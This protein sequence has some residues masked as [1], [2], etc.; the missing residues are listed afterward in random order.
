MKTPG[1][2]ASNHPI[3]IVLLPLSGIWALA[4]YLRSFRK[5]KKVGAYVICVGNVVAGG[6][7]K[8]PVALALGSYLQQQHVPAYFITRGY[9]ASIQNP[10]LVDVKQHT[11]SDVGDEALL[12][13]K[14]LPTIACPDRVRAAEYAV[15]LG[16]KI[17]IMDDGMQNPT[18]HKDYTILVLK[19]NQP[20]GNGRLMPAGPLREPYANALARAQAIVTI[21][22]DASVNPGT[23][24]AYA[25]KTKLTS[26]G[27]RF[28]KYIAFAGIA[29]PSAFKQSLECAGYQLA[30]FHAFADHHPYSTHELERLASLAK[31][32]S[33]PLITT[34]KDAVRL[35]AAFKET[36]ALIVAHQHLQWVDN[37]A[38]AHL[39]QPPLDFLQGHASRAP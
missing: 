8:T 35:P 29:N 22:A 2:W 6:G 14:V 38:L 32:S 17:I 31:N 20:L 4:A 27:P 19:G 21:D 18:L 25:A 30:G 16:A 13:A 9:G 5:A 39:S 36:T 37:Q 1:W 33:Y 23:I 3:S 26:D 15:S 12:L 11:A 28:E 34:A 10:I 24:P 7:G